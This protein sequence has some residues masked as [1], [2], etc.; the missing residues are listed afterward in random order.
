M[1]FA[2][3]LRCPHAHA[4][5]LKV[6]TNEA[7]VMPGVAAI[8]DPSSAEAGAGWRYGRYST[9][10][11]DQVCRYE[12]EV[13]AAV[14]AETQDQA[15]DALRA[16]EVEYEVLPFV[17]DETRALE[18][19]AP[20][21]HEGG[22]LVGGKPSR[23]ER[24]DLE[25]GFAEADVVLESTYRTDCE[26]HNPLERHG[27]VARW[28]GDR[29]TVWESSQGVFS[30]QLWL[31]SILGLPLANVRVICPYMGGGF[32]SKLQP[33]KYTVLAALLAKRAGR[34]VKLI[35]SREECLLA[36]GNRPP[37]HM[38]LKAGVKRD[39]TLTALDFTCTGTGGAYQAGGTSLVDWEVKD[40]YAC[41]NV[42]T[43]CTD[44]Y[45]NAGPARPFR[46]PGHPQ[47]AWALEQMIDALA[48]EIEM[49]P[50]AL[51]L[52]NIATTSQANDGNPPY[53]STGLSLCLERGAREF[54]WST[55]RK[56]EGDKG[57]IRRGVGVA[58]S[59]WVVGGGG[60]PSTVIVKMYSDGSVN[61]NMGASDLGTGTRTVMAMVVAEELAVAPEQIQVEN[62]DTGTT[63]FASSSGGSKTVPTESPATRAA[64]MDV[65]RQLLEIAAVELETTANDL[66]LEQSKVVSR[67]DPDKQIAVNELAGLRRRRVLVGVGY[68]G[69]N[70]EGKVVNPFA[71][72]FCE[73]EVNIRTGE[74]RVVRFVAAHDSGRM[75]NQL[76]YRNQ[77]CGGINMGIGFGM[78]EVRTLDRR[79]TGKLVNKNL[80]DYKMPTALDV[81][82]EV[83][84]LVIDLNDTEANTTGAKGLGEPATIP[85]AAAIANAVFNATGVRVTETPIN[86]TR[87]CRLL[88]HAEKEG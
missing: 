41:A 54:G 77:V 43:E 67:S 88:A 36:V 60:P 87:M 82:T 19:S 39:G 76:T 56:A 55:A 10:L 35:L 64:A 52:K 2:A 42:R 1:L 49:D 44:V 34:P 16:I 66:R 4:R 17:A 57:Q 69:P 78:T 31:S 71:A 50:V 75:M 23:Y 24:G 30:V 22:N 79:Q 20:A 8:I 29:L 83:T 7:S 25:Q 84:P 47:G 37:S 74:V 13:V 5:V 28:E 53:T 12:G 58:A 21:I 6:D 51:R 45:I 80:H 3:I 81:P 63:Q 85:T 68:R 26:I 86:P 11:I 62:A 40:L 18:E 70:P 73:V 33:G 14:A 59:H 65:K 9:T 27:C 32:G 46:A 61:L 72:Q 15:Q 48:E 38:W